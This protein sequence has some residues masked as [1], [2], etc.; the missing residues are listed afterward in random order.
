MRKLI[1]AAAI[2]MPF[3]AHAGD[4]SG[5]WKTEP[6]DEGSYLK[7]EI[8]PC[9][10]KLCG[11]IL[12]GFRADGSENADY[13]HKGRDMIVDMVADGENEWEDGTIWAPD[14]DETYDAKMELDGDVLRVEGCVL[15]ICRGQDWTRAN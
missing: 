5:V 13:E 6:N 3:A 12:G 7:V 14:D 9:G 4:P 2:A 11:V 15:F 8:G 1:L 10:E